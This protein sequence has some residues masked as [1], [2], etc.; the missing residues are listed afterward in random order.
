MAFAGAGCD[1]LTGVHCWPRTP[2]DPARGFHLMARCAHRAFH[3]QRMTLMLT[4]MAV[5]TVGFPLAPERRRS[6]AGRVPR[7][8]VCLPVL[9]SGTALVERIVPAAEL[10]EGITWTSTGMALGWR[11][12]CLHPDHH[13]FLGRAHRPPAHRGCA[14]AACAVSWVGAR[15]VHRAELRALDII[16]A[17]PPPSTA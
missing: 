4:V 3:G 15:T 8:V 1:L 7:R 2:S 17:K 12:Q 14:I 10:T 16:A 9:I 5:V 13:R 6:R 11:W